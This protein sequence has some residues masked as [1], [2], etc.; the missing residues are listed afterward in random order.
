MYPSFALLF[1]NGH[2]VGT[3]R[4][5]VSV[6][7]LIEQLSLFPR[8]AARPPVG[9]RWEAGKVKAWVATGNTAAHRSSF[10]TATITYTYTNG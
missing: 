5:D 4:R 2:L 10:H 6:S 8:A 9:H 7:H 1:N 3:N